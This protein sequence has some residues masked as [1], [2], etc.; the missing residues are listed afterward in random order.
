LF[1]ETFDDDDPRKRLAKLPIKHAGMALPDPVNS[2]KPN[3]QSSVLMTGHLTAALRGAVEFRSEDHIK[4][5]QVARFELKGRKEMRNDKTLE[6]LVSKLPAFERRTILRGRL[7][8]QYLTV[9]PS[10][11][12]STQLS[13]QEFRDSILIRYCRSPPDLPSHCDG[14]SQSFSVPHALACKKG[15]LVI[16]RHNEIRD[17]LFDIAT[18]AFPPSSVR[19]EPKIN[20]CRVVEPEN[21]PASVDR[22]LAKNNG[23]ERGDL[24]I[25][26]LWANGTDCIIDV[27]MTDTDAPSYRNREPVKVLE[28]QEREKK[29]KYLQPCLDQRRHFSP[30]VVSTD[31]MLGK[32]ATTLLKKLSARIAEKHGGTYSHVCGAMRAR[33]SIAIVR[34]THLCLRGSR[35]PASQMSNRRLQWED[36]A[37]L[38]SFRF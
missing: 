18:K 13:P 1:G 25:R 33:M 32:E 5:C 3:Y 9:T 14:C 16:T 11:V 17:E 35:I 2:A 34:A 22:N 30:F 31:G 8:G 12:H 38:A 15:G 28:S 29:K 21:S 27:R 36:S 4:T 23:E 19:D 20:P 7:T 24:L 37:G 10:V 26:S 6:A